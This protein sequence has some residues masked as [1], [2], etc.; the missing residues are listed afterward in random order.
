MSA[1]AEM[2]MM[3]WDIGRMVEERQHLEGWGAAVIPR[4]SRDIHND[5][6]EIKGFS[7]RNL[8]RMIRF[9]REYSGLVEKVPQAVAQ[10]PEQAANEKG[11]MEAWPQIEFTDDRE[12][13]LFT[14]MVRRSSEKVRRKFT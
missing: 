12:G 3:Y 14:V 11:S 4:L 9:Y 7:E 6:P 1:S 13:C 2:I 5:L 10:L 8:K